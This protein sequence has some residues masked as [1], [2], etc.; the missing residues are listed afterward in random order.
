MKSRI[1][2]VSGTPWEALRGFSRAVVVGD[3][4]FISGTTA[5]TQTGEVV[6]VN[7]PYEQSRFIFDRL[8][9]ILSQ[10]GFALS[11]IVRTRVYTLSMSYYDEIARAHR[12][13]FDEVRPASSMVQVQR[14]VDPRLL[15]EI[16]FD[17]IRESAPI[18]SICL[19]E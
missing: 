1:N 12:E 15:V 17:G 10:N 14:L 7:K 11:D 18:S 19:E 8:R 13:C 4:I 2:I 6:G 5:F 16:E 9:R 3:Q